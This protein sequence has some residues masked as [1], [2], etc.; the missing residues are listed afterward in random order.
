MNTEE[1]IKIWNN[2]FPNFP[3]VPSELKNR[4]K[5]RWLRIHTLPKSKRYPENEGEYN[6]IL[7]RHNL[8]LSDL[9]RRNHQ[10]FLITFH[11]GYKSEG[12]TKDKKLQKLNL[13]RNLWCSFKADEF[14][15]DSFY[16]HAYFDE[17]IWKEHLFDALFR[18][19]IDDEVEN[20][21]FFSTEKNILYHPYDGGADI[22][23]INSELRDFYKDKYKDWLSKHPLEL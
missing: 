6:E 8:I 10:Y 2:N 14:D 18:L 9:F 11:Y 15:N 5:E 17:H 20:V 16:W 1:L 23:F 13:Q 12:L 3:P 19:V 7:Q 4:F 22:F 21:M